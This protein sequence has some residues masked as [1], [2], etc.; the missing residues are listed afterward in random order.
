L[1]S[2]GEFWVIAV[3]GVWVG[4]CPNFRHGLS[5][6]IENIMEV[7]KRTRASGGVQERR[8]YQGIGLAKV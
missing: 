1:K 3:I 6:H 5:N 8:Y 4:A 2:G 7:E